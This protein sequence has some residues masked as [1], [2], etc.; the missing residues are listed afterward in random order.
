MVKAF[1]PFKRH[2]KSLKKVI[3]ALKA[4]LVF[5]LVY[6]PVQTVINIFCSVLGEFY[7]YVF[8]TGS[9]FCLILVVIISPIITLSNTN[10]GML[11]LI[12]FNASVKVKK[13]SK[14]GNGKDTSKERIVISDESF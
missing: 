9:I 12:E 4:Y 14:S 6:T 2:E 11:P 8:A 1:N 3:F 13:V 10:G 5:I 7:Q